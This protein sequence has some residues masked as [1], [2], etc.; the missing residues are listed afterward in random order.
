RISGQ[1]W[2][3]T[4]R[5]PQESTNFTKRA[6]PTLL[7]LVTPARSSRTFA[8][9]SGKSFASKDSLMGPLSSSVPSADFLTWKRMLLLPPVSS[10]QQHSKIV[11][12]HGALAGRARGPRQIAEFER[13][14]GR[15]R[16]HSRGEARIA[17]R[18]FH[19][20]VC[21]RHERLAG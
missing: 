11:G 19:D 18:P 7:M 1:R 10:D 12:Q 8:A 9:S 20:A 16:F 4:G 14:R 15:F 6:T 5:P 3:S 2:Y 17:V 13:P 21:V